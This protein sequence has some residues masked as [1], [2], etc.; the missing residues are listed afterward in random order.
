LP[1]AFLLTGIVLV[2]STG[3]TRLAGL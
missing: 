1:G 3:E 2:R